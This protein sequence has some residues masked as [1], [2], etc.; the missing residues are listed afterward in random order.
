MTM[1]MINLVII[2]QVPHCTDK[3][4]CVKEHTYNFSLMEPKICKFWFLHTLKCS[5]HCT[6]QPLKNYESRDCF[7]KEVT[8]NN[9]L[10]I[11]KIT[12]KLPNFQNS[13]QINSKLI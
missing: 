9:M 2:Y 3:Y 12:L 6:L 8:V 10:I 5:N 7:K 13:L 4:K 1:T 11:T